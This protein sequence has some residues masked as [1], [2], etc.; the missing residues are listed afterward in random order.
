MKVTGFFCS[1]AFSLRQWRQKKA[2]TV[3]GHLPLTSPCRVG[4][5]E[6]SPTHQTASHSRTCKW[7]PQLHPG[8]C[9]GGN[10]LTLPSVRWEG[11][12]AGSGWLTKNERKG[13]GEGECRMGKLVWQCQTY[14]L[15]LAS[16]SRMNITCSSKFFL[17]WLL[18]MRARKKS[19]LCFSHNLLGV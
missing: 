11:M 3:T 6:T 18:L 19:T 5:R 12:K 14:P 7:A 16:V 15:L 10:L 13:W 9:L 4:S 8:S 17:L 1:S 2:A